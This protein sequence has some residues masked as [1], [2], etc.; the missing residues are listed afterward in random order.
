MPKKGGLE[1][2]ADLTRGGLGKKGGGGV[3]DGGGGGGEGDTPMH[4]MVS[5][6]CM[7]LA[8]ST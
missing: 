5:K 2:F 1:Q 4:T 7:N 8:L 3:F 6:S